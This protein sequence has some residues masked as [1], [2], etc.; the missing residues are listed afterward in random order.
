M[1]KMQINNLQAEIDQLQSKADAQLE[2]ITAD[3]VSERIRLRNGIMV[4][5]ANLKKRMARPTEAEAQMSYGVTY[6]GKTPLY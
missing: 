3:N 4:K 2:G 1:N 6:V 5:I